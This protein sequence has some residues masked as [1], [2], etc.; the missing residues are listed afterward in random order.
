MENINFFSTKFG[1]KNSIRDRK[2]HRVFFQRKINTENYPNIQK[3]LHKFFNDYSHYFDT[4]FEKNH[5]VVGKKYDPN[6]KSNMALAL[7]ESASQKLRNKRLLKRPTMKRGNIMRSDSMSRSRV[8]NDEKRK[9]FEDS[10]LKPGQRFIEDKEIDKIFYLYR[11]LRKINKNRSKNFINMKELK[12]LKEQQETKNDKNFITKST[13]NFVKMN[14]INNDKR[15]ILNNINVEEKKYGTIIVR[16][17]NMDINNESEYNKTISTNMGGTILDDFN[18]T[19]NNLKSIEV[20][21]TQKPYNICN[22]DDIK[23]RKKIIERQNQYLYKNLELT[24]K[25]QFAE[26]LASQESTILCQNKNNKFQKHFNKYLYNH[27]KKKPDSRLL[28]LDDTH[29]RNRELKMKIEYFQNKLNPDRIYDW[30]YDLHSWKKTLPFFDTKIETIRNPKNMKPFNNRKSKTIEKD[31]YL[32]NIITSKNCK[33][34]EKELNN[35]NNNYDGLIVE[36]KNLLQLENNVAKKLKGRKI[37]NDFEKLMT[38]S[39]LKNENIYSNILK[40]MY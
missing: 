23:R 32:K 21:K 39:D 17:N 40:K 22:T 30:Y 27:L 12:E 19:N 16:N 15:F 1:K 8:F 2:T 6:Q 35:I 29:R 7:T 10:F 25:K 38:P 34:L 37:I 24:I 3:K 9:S 14:S 28:I 36:G 31:D 33:H 5:I 20:D 26:N 13:D 11:E 18:K 4:S